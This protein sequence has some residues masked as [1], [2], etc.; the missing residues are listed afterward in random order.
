MITRK[1]FA[2]LKEQS[3]IASI[4]VVP[5]PLSQKWCIDAVVRVPLEAGSTTDTVSSPSNGDDDKLRKFD[6]IDDAAAFLRSIGVTTFTV[7]TAD[8]VS[9]V[10]IDGKSVRMIETTMRFWEDDD[11]G[12]EARLAS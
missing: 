9:F 5:V 3:L 1:R 4:R 6:S 10:N 7:D 11:T 8:A 12:S 2:E